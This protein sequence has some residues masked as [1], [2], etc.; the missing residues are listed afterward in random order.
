MWT[1]DHCNHAGDHK[2][3]PEEDRQQL[4][5]EQ[6]LSALLAEHLFAKQARHPAWVHLLHPQAHGGQDDEMGVPVVSLQGQNYS[7]GDRCRSPGQA[8]GYVG[9]PGEDVGVA[10]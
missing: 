7:L 4:H 1:K 5:V 2:H 8:E 6:L 10:W 3:N 9:Q